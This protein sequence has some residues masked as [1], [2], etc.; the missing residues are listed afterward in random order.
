MVGVDVIFN[1]LQILKMKPVEVCIYL[2]AKLVI[3]VGKLL[4]NNEEFYGRV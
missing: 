4:I 2:G 1:A 3:F